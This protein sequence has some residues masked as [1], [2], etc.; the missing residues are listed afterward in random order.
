MYVHIFSFLNV[1]FYHNAELYAIL[2][3]LSI[4]LFNSFLMGN[5]LFFISAMYLG[6]YNSFLLNVESCQLLL[7]LDFFFCV[8]TFFHIVLDAVL[9]TC[10]YSM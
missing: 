3:E 9:P 5:I 6:N 10:N 7:E 1:I 4:F 8:V 2:E